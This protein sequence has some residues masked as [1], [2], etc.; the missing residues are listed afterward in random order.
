MFKSVHPIQ[1]GN[2]KINNWKMN[3]FY[4]WFDTH[5]WI[6]LAG[7]DYLSDNN[8]LSM[9]IFGAITSPKVTT[10]Y[11][12]KFQNF[13]SFLTKFVFVSFVA[14]VA[15]N[16]N[17]FMINLKNYLGFIEFGICLGLILEQY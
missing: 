7:A 4:D 3:W 11:I 10:A 9:I 13:Q 6:D 8:Y 1:N 15:K 5:K 2:K 16:T 17:N 14:V 12:I